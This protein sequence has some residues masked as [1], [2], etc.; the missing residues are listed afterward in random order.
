LSEVIGALGTSRRWDR[1][2]F[3]GDRKKRGNART[4]FDTKLHESAHGKK[5]D[6]RYWG[7]RMGKGLKGTGTSRN[8]GA[9][10]AMKLVGWQKKG[11]PKTPKRKGGAID[12][13][14]NG[15]CCPPFFNDVGRIAG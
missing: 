3:G 11:K 10:Q 14:E 8:R 13:K 15:N 7:G 4:T 9:V 12:E 6:P 2:G 5:S 1:G